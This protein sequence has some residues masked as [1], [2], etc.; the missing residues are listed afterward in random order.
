MVPMIILICFLSYRLKVAEDK[1]RTLDS[2]RE[3]LLSLHSQEV[4]SLRAAHSKALET[5]MSYQSENDK[6]RS[7]VR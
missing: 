3:N 6:L 7:K 2:E 1:V 4:S 5:L